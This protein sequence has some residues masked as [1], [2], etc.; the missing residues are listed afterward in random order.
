MSIN[1]LFTPEDLR[2]PGVQALIAANLFPLFGVLFFGWSLFSIMLLYWL[3]NIVIGIFNVIRMRRAEKPMPDA[4]A[5]VK[6]GGKPYAPEMKGQLIAFFILH[7]GLF[8]AV[9]GVF[10]FALFRSDEAPTLAVVVGLV[11][12]LWSHAV[13]YFTNYI[14]KGEYKSLSA[15]D[16]FIQPYKRIFVLHLTIIFGGG[17]SLAIGSPIFALVVL[18]A[19]KITVDIWLHLHERDVFAKH[20]VS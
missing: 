10:V 1:K 3:E 15:P 19:L 17:F 13:S 20:T 18:I 8:T 16:L 9:H 14:G 4:E 6:L 5:G 12:L 2:A 11:S 7:Y